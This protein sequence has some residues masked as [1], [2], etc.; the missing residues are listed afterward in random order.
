MSTPSLW[1]ETTCSFQLPTQT[2]VPKEIDIAIVGGGIT[3]ITT[4]YYL[5]KTGKQIALLE[6]GKILQ[7]DTALTT[8]FFS[9][10]LEATLTDL[11]KTFD[12]TTAKN[13][14]TSAQETIETVANLITAEQIECEASRCLVEIYACNR[15]GKTQLETE[16]EIAKKLGIPLFWS[17]KSPTFATHG[18]VVLEQQLKLH[19]LKYLQGLLARAIEYGAQVHEETHVHEIE[20]RG[21]F[22]LFTSQGKITAQMLVIATH[23]PITH[24]L[25]FPSRL[26]AKRTYVIQG[27]LSKDLVPEGLYWD[28]AEPYHYFRVDRGEDT[29]RFLFGGEDH[30]TGEESVSTDEHFEKLER[31]FRALL[32]TAS[33]AIERRWSGQVYESIDRLPYIGRPMQEQNEYVATG[34]GGDGMVFGSMSGKIISELICTGSHPWAELYKTFRP[35]G[36]G[37][38][39]KQGAH[40]AKELIKKNHEAEVKSV[41]DIPVGTGKIMMEDGKPVAVFKSPQGKILKCSAVCTHLRCTVHWNDPEKSWDCPCH[42]SRFDTNGTVLNGPASEPLPRLE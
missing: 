6:Q 9:Q 1:Q 11:V 27:T 26:S 20:G 17:R 7:G 12:E 3:G 28:T 40:F 38:A 30:L 4:A 21:P 36:V 31:V 14:W 29:D 15:D 19:P 25:E 13:I 35:H 18:S 8:A 32:P 42:G 5:A 33:I 22:T 39:L 16:V 2:S 23:S 34:F 24:P 37:Q 10:A 41:D